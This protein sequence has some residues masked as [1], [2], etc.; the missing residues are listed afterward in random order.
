[1]A[2]SLAGGQSGLDAAGV[3]GTGRRGALRRGKLRAQG[4]TYGGETRLARVTAVAGGEGLR[5]GKSGAKKEYDYDTH[6]HDLSLH[7]KILFFASKGLPSGIYVRGLKIYNMEPD[8]SQ[9]EIGA[10]FYH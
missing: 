1:M 3:V 5:A 8:N 4:L 9:Q 10:D 7:R 6:Y 2:G